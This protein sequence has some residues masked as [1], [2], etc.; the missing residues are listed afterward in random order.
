MIEQYV[1]GF[2][3]AYDEH[4]SP[5]PARVAAELLALHRLHAPDGE[6]RLLDV[7][8]GTGI[9]GAHFQAAGYEVTGLDASQAMLQRARARLGDGAVLVH[10]DAAEFTLDRTFPFAV[11]TY[12]LPNHLGGMARIRGYLECVYRA[13]QPGGLF[14]FDVATPK[15]LS[16]INSV[17]VRETED[18][19]LV[20][21]GALDEA[22]GVGLYHISGAVRAADG[23]YDRFQTT[24]TNS[25]VP[26]D[27]LRAAL[28]ETGWRDT[29]LAATADLGTPLAAEAEDRTRVF[30]VSHRPG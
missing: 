19:L 30:L 15:G 24:I 27:Q 9:V 18:S 8:C 7:G 2:A 26:L 25:V 17:Q 16:S 10:G 4:W 20:Y 3:G 5:Y 28:R 22:A 23:R 11:S 1:D 29:Y 6:R 13:V 14:A 21:R 12:D